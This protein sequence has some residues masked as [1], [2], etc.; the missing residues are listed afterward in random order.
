[1]FEVH[2]LAFGRPD[3]A[4]LVEALRRSAA[5]IS[6]LSLVAI[7]GERVVGHV[8]FSRIVVGCAAA[9]QPALALAPM[10]VLPPHQRAGVGSALV[11]HGL[12]EARRL[13]HRVVV[14]VGHP[15]YYPRFGFVPAEPLGIRPPFAVA[16]GACMA[17]ELEPDALQG[18]RGELTYP[19]EFA[20]V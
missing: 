9:S 7:V 10:A 1:M 8:L 12:A 13:G 20:E 16:P 19:A 18:V 17:L 15:E 2:R 14:V 6:E 3:E 5:F 4:R 11:R